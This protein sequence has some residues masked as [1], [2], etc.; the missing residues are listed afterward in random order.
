ME[1]LLSDKSV[2]YSI[3]SDKNTNACSLHIL[4][5]MGLAFE[6]EE[7]EREKKKP[8]R[9]DNNNKKNL[10]ERIVNAVDNLQMQNF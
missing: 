1:W 7:I 10:I 6:I 5:L 9:R 8:E 2:V 4:H 3:A